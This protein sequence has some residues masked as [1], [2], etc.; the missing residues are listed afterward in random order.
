MWQGALSTAL[1]SAACF[2][3]AFFPHWKV[4]WGRFGNGPPMSVEGRIAF[5]AFLAFLSLVFLFAPKSYLPFV[6]A[7]PLL[8]V[9]WSYAWR[10]KARQRLKEEQ[11]RFRNG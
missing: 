4:R 6:G 3:S 10:D 2:A 1:A 9:V 7:V 11:E 8:I 5:G